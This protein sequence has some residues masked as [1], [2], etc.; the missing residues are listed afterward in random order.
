MT[1]TSHLSFLKRAQIGCVA[2]L[3]GGFAIF[4][5]IFVIDLGLG[6]HGA[7]YKVVGFATGLDGIEAT[8]FGMVSHM[9]TASLIGTVFGLGSGLHKILDIHSIKKGALGGISTGLA[10]FFVFFVPISTF[11]I[12]PLIQENRQIAEADALLSN[13]NL[14]MIGAIEMHVVYGMVMG[15]FFAIA[16]Q[17][18]S[19]K[20]IQQARAA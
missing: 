3:V 12:V 19:K 11:L 7:F 6:A 20:M 13:M 1:M 8:L 14:I 16:V 15:A 2:G 4:V 9:L 10:V 5:S 17:V 18:E